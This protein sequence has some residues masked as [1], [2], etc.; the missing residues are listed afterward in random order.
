MWSGNQFLITSPGIS[1]F[2]T[3]IALIFL[4]IAKRWPKL[5]SNTLSGLIS[6]RPMSNFAM[7][8]SLHTAIRKNKLEGIRN[9]INN[10]NSSDKHSH[11][12]TN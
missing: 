1:S 8:T 2:D 4:T 6:P 9:G 12:H 11:S 7:H 3:S 10:T 5:T